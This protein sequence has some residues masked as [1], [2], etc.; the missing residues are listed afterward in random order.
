M[1]QQVVLKAM[2]DNNAI[3]QKERAEALNAPL[4]VAK[5][6]KQDSG[7]LHFVFDELTSLSEKYHFKIGG[8]VEIFT[9]LDQTIQAKMEEIA[10]AHSETDKTFL[11]ADKENNGF[12]AC[13][14]T[15][16]NIP[17]LPGSIIKPLLVYAPA[18]EENLLSP[19]TP[20]LDE[21]INYNGYSPE[22]Y[23]GTYHGYV[24]VREC[25][26]KSLNVPAVRILSSL[27]VHKGAK[28][29]EK[30]GLPVEA[31]DKS[32]ALAL[33]GMKNG[34]TLKDI[35]SAYSSLQNDGIYQPC[36]FI[37]SV[38][39]N[40]VT[41]YKKT[42]TG[43]KVFSSATASLMTDILKSTAKNGTAKKLR[44]VPFEV[45]AK[46]GTVGSNKGNTD[47]YALSYTTRDCAAVWLGNIDNSKIEHTGGGEPC[48]ILRK[49]NEAVYSIY[50]TRQQSIPDFQLDKTIRKVQLDKPAYYDTHTLLLADENSPQEY[51]LSELFKNSEIPL[52][53]STSFTSPS[54]IPPKLSLSNN[55]VKIAFDNR[56]PHYYTYK[57]ERYDYVTHTTLYNGK[58]TS[59]FCDNSLQED[60]N[61]IYTV[62]P[63]FNG[64]EGTPITLPTISTRKGEKAELNQEILSKEWWEY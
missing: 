30:L 37:S 53:K 50:Q 42:K 48:T 11:V 33:G 4:P 62:T 58:F 21:K 28:Y 64:K 32:L 10:E 54:I 7:Y 57:I 8:K 26:E 20:I 6:V 13:V 60:K 25:V 45:A 3:T 49:I 15:V 34:Y 9:F 29:L 19:A 59:E 12:K 39:I 40:G 52:N 41:V 1:R 16:G 44:G 14:S 36:T 22:N 63:I 61:Y 5:S 56:F 51:R 2:L 23:D 35:V 43:Q 38:A 17:R 24:S 55:T 31:E 47:A 27:T 46:T 18:M